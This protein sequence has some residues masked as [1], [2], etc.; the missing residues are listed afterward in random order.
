MVGGQEGLCT[1]IIPTNFKLQVA[2]QG[3]SSEGH[4]H[5][6][7]FMHLVLFPFQQHILTERG[8]TTG[9]SPCPVLHTLD[10]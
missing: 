4:L 10:D 2:V 7:V 6:P 3:G 8:T 5:L 1:L 9:L